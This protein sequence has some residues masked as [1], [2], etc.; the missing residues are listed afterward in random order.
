MAVI[1]PICLN[2]D[3][4]KNKSHNAKHG[5]QWSYMPSPC[6]CLLG[7]IQKGC[8]IPKGEKR[9]KAKT[10][11]ILACGTSVRLSSLPTTFHV[12]AVYKHKE[13]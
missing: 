11:M 1:W 9:P 3:R 4:N 2:R 10:N 5:N 13:V 8:S 6:Y 7:L 12:N